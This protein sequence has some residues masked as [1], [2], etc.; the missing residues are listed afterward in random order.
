MSVAIQPLVV[1]KAGAMIQIS[2][3]ALYVRR[4]L[5]LIYKQFLTFLIHSL[6]FINVLWINER[7]TPIGIAITT[8]TMTMTMTMTV[9]M[10][11]I[12]LTSMMILLL[13]LLSLL[14][15][16]VVIVVVVVVIVVV[17]YYYYYYNNYN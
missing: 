12:M 7:T 4:F 10:M 5:R 3:T 13:L 17:T 9:M 15:P 8:T 14:L 11:I 2:P 16:L 1:M 6:W